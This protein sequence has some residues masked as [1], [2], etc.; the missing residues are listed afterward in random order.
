MPEKQV[1]WLIFPKNF[2]IKVSHPHKLLQKAKPFK[3]RKI[4]NEKKMNKQSNKAANKNKTNACGGR[5]KPE[6]REENCK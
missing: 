2:C 1:F 6:N 5:C 4:M 3:R